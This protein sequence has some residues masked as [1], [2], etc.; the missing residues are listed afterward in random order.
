MRWLATHEQRGS[1]LILT[2]SASS[3]AIFKTVVDML[4]LVI[5]C[6]GEAASQPC[7]GRRDIIRPRGAA[8]SRGIRS[9]TISGLQSAGCIRYLL[10]PSPRIGTLQWYV[11]TGSSVVP[12]L[13]VDMFFITQPCLGRCS[14]A[15]AD[16]YSL[17]QLEWGRG[18][19]VYKLN[20]PIGSAVIRVYYR[21]RSKPSP[22]RNINRSNTH[23]SLKN[24][25]CNSTMSHSLEQQVQNILAFTGVSSAASDAIFIAVMGVTGAGKSTFVSQCTGQDVSIGHG[26][27]SCK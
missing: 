27:L 3:S 25:Q 8:F 24:N 11:R 16:R 10:R 1:S 4:N 21:R 13:G 6:S 5:E 17:A 2:F 14:L 20:S 23:R 18:L 7:S 12:S 22:L 9:G 15:L 26:L 19:S